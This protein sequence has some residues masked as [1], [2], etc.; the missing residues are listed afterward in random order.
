MEKLEVGSYYFKYLSDSE[1]KQKSVDGIFKCE[2]EIEH[3]IKC[4]RSLINA[5]LPLQ[6]KEKRI[7]K[8]V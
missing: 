1:V 4:F 6:I 7:Y 5:I 2:K 3:L 8:T